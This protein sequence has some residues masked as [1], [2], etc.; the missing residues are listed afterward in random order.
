MNDMAFMTTHRATY[1][2]E[3]V[4]AQLALSVGCPDAT[5]RIVGRNGVIYGGFMA[6]GRVP[7]NDIKVPGWPTR[8]GI[9]A[10]FFP[11]V[12]DDAGPHPVDGWLG[13]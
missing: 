12:L 13:L 4:D 10:V 7:G 8:R 6:T 1:R 5:H 11:A 3:A 9:R 2:V